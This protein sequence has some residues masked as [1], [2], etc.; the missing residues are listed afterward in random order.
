MDV[1]GEGATGLE[2]GRV[3]EVIAGGSHGTQGRRGSGYRLT[4]RYVVTSAHIVDPVPATLRVRFDADRPTEW[5]VSARI[6]L[7]SAS[8]DLALLDLG[9]LPAGVPAGL[10]PPRYAAVPEA[11]VTLPVS[12]VGFP[13]FKYRWDTPTAG[14]PASGYRDSCHVDGMVPALSNRRAGTLEVTVTPPADHVGPD[15]SPW[16]GMSGAALWWDGAF[17]GIIAAHHRSDGLGRLT[18]VRMARWYEALEASE[19]D[20]LCGCLGMPRDLAAPGGLSE[21]APARPLTALS[22]VEMWELT[23]ALTALPS[24]RRPD[25]MAAV[26]EDADARL[27]A[28]RPRDSRL[29]FEVH[30]LLRTCRSYTGSFGPVVAALRAAEQDSE[31]MRAVEQLLHRMNLKYE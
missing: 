4:D 9:V 19:W 31:E 13:L 2:I 11:D 6:A 23:D 21:A 1:D 14:G 24:L 7:C 12:A 28:H 27:A 18:A 29:R 5:L 26:L 15:R 25:G 30:G 17:I 20:L 16:E 3:A 22:P 8:A 10:R